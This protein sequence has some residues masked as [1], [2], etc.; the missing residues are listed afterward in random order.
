[1]PRR[2]TPD[3]PPAAHRVHEA[4]LRWSRRGQAHDLPLRPGGDGTLIVPLAALAAP[5]RRSGDDMAAPGARGVRRP[6]VAD[7]GSTS[8]DRT[9]S[10]DAPGPAPGDSAAWAQALAHDLRGRDGIADARVVRRRATPGPPDTLVIDVT[11]A[12]AADAV[13]TA[14]ASGDHGPRRDTRAQD[15]GQ[16]HA[17]A[18]IHAQSQARIQ[19][20]R[21]GVGEPTGRPARTVAQAQETYARGRRVLRLAARSGVAPRASTPQPA[22]PQQ[23]WS[24]AQRPR[25]DLPAGPAAHR[26]MIEIADRP[27]ASADTGSAARA[28]AEH[29]RALVAALDAYLDQ[30]ATAAAPPDRA[31]GAAPARPGEEAARIRLV[32]AACAALARALHKLGAAAPDRL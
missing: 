16:I 28:H 6:G 10:P 12:L 21:A 30:P 31:T 1:M 27:R 32:G 15:P 24:P 29:L 23:R 14:L 20:L 8:G 18:E 2:S 5:P 9:D 26:L 7:G 11:T 13:T 4:L 3:P 17:H 25:T 22:P 19:A